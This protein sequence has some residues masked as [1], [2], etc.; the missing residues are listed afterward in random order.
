MKYITCK[1]INDKE[2]STFDCEKISNQKLCCYY[3]Q[4]LGDCPNLCDES[5]RHMT[6]VDWLLHKVGKLKIKVV[7]DDK[8]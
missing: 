7:W 5:T 6:P 3:C 1:H 2:C 8:Y 4:E